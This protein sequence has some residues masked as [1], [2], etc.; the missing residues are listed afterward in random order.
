MMIFPK[1]LPVRQ[2][3][4]DTTLPSV[5]DATR[6]EL[7]TLGLEERIKPGQTVALTAG[8]R[9]ITDF[10]TVLRT[11]VEALKAIGA[12]PF[13][14]PSMGSHG[15]GTAEGQVGVLR[16]YKISEESMGCPIRASME[17][18]VLG[19]TVDGIK[20]HLDRHAS[21]ADHIGVIGRVKPHTNFN[22]EIESG[23]FKMMGIGLGKHAGAYSYHKASLRLGMAD[24]VLSVGRAVLGWAKITF[25]V[26]IVENAF[27]RAA[28]VRAVWNEGF[29]A[30]EKR[31][32]VEAKRLM[33]KLP[34]DEIDL[35][36][37]DEIG[38]D[39]SGGGM[40][41]NVIGKIAHEFNWE[42]AERPVVR[43]IFVRDLTPET[44]GNACGLGLADFCTQRIVDKMDR[45]STYTNVITSGN[46]A[47]ARIPVICES[48][49]EALEAALET[50]GELD[51]AQARIVRIRNTLRLEEMEASEAFTKEINAR[52]DL[53]ALEGPRPLS[54]DTAGN[55]T[56][57][58]LG[59]VAR[60]A[61]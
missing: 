47:S 21:Q 50:L 37:V 23:L 40:D 52:D 16:H 18:V 49:R 60:A 53:E 59:G 27:D 1:M 61:A 10:P 13:I 28:I 43:R 3:F 45:V 6:R 42:Y 14:V 51:P 19:E 39:V 9:G 26:G 57:A 38:K 25:G 5:A 2:K 48:D 55:L 31:L 20:V 46:P 7:R 11:T 4:D 15:G 29:E 35:L 41:S 56:P 32:L 24:M 17:T 30:E 8:S 58:L 36:I 22:A 44:D 12:K 54:F 34:F 33:G